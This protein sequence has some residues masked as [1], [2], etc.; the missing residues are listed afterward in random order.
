MAR[1]KL[2]AADDAA[3][4]RL[5]GAL[6]GGAAV[7]GAVLLDGSPAGDPVEARGITGGWGFYHPT[8][9][10][11]D[12]KITGV[13]LSADLTVPDSTEKEPDR[14][15]V[16]QV[17][18]DVTLPEPRPVRAGEPVSVV[19]VDWPG[20]VGP[21]DLPPDEAAAQEAV[22]QAPVNAPQQEAASA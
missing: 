20:L 19:L 4:E 15:K 8:A 13:R 1:K 12:G 22:T 5:R 3:L 16:E 10:S 6:R 14:T 9:A 11:A 17:G 7:R 18:G 2:S 21:G